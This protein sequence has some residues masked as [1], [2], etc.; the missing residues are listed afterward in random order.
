V[1][2]NPPANKQEAKSALTGSQI[3]SLFEHII[4]TVLGAPS[5]PKDLEGGSLELSLWSVDALMRAR[6]KENAKDSLEALASIVRLVEKIENMPVHKDVRD[7]VLAALEELE[8]VSSPVPH[9]WK[10]ETLTT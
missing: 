8:T 5:L 3:F 10:P 4:T 7:G 9:T 2:S 6:A 1:I